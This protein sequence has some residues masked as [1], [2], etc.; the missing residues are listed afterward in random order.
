MDGGLPIRNEIVTPAS[1]V[2]HTAKTYLLGSFQCPF[3][4]SQLSECGDAI[5]AFPI[6]LAHKLLV[7]CHTRVQ[8]LK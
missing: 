2:T 5:V 8:T 6:K 3:T 7:D 4:R 1:F